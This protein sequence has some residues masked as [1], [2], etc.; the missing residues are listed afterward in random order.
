MGDILLKFQV[1]IFICY[2][3]KNY[4][5]KDL[6]FL[7][8]DDNKNK[9]YPIGFK[10][11]TEIS[12]LYRWIVFVAQKIPF[13]SNKD[14]WGKKF[15]SLIFELRFLRELLIYRLEIYPLITLVVSNILLK[16]QVIIFICCLEKNHCR[17]NFSFIVVG[18]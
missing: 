4:L 5:R 7:L 16:F 17:K 11:V 2:L 15:F 10:F 14:I 13:I 1:V 9:N 12:F 8:S 6:L 3:E 18:R